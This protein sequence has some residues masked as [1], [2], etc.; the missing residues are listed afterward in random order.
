MAR[1]DDAEEEAEEA[2]ERRLEARDGAGRRMRRKIGVLAAMHLATVWL[3][4][5]GRGEHRARSWHPPFSPREMRTAVVDA[6]TPSAGLLDLA[7]LTLA[8]IVYLGVIVS[9]IAVR[10]GASGKLNSALVLQKPLRRRRATLET[11]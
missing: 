11:L 3:S 7:V 9:A 8:R 10:E 4:C 5:M 6:Y 2:R 1:E